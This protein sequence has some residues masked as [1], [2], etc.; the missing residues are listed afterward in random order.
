GTLTRTENVTPPVSDHAAVPR[1]SGKGVIVGGS[2][3]RSGCISCTATS[4]AELYD[5]GTGTFTATSHTLVGA[6]SSPTATLLPS[7]KVL[8]AGGGVTPSG[9]P[10]RTAELY[11]PVADT[12]TSIASTM[13][14]ARQLHSA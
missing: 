13:S 5:P 4:S 12:F 14:V 11:D 7:G 1:A 10:V 8:V 9:G 3:D 6:R 2:V